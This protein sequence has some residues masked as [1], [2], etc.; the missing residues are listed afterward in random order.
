MKKLAAYTVAAFYLVSLLAYGASAESVN[1]ATF[2][3]SPVGDFQTLDTTSSVWLAAQNGARV[4]VGNVAPAATLDVAN[5]ATPE[6][7]GMTVAD[8]SMVFWNGQSEHQHIYTR[9]GT[10]NSLHIESDSA[11]GDGVWLQS[12]NANVGIG[13]FGPPF[14]P[15]DVPLS[16]VH[17]KGDIGI[18]TDSGTGPLQLQIQ[19]GNAYCV[20]VYE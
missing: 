17:V 3:P 11:T 5:T 4:G 18:T 20:V 7:T 12:G 2:Y 9:A 15:A 10:G 16:T 8:G 14:A 13:V 6:N 19:G 1:V